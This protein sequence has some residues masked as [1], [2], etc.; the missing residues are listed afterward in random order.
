MV[1]F[2]SADGKSLLFSQ[3]SSA[4]GKVSGS[5]VVNYADTSIFATLVINGTSSS[6]IT[7]PILRDLGGDMRLVVNILGI[8][9]T[10]M[11]GSGYSSIVDSDGDGVPDSKDAFPKDSSKAFTIR[12]PSTGYNTLT[13]EDQYPSVGDKD[14]ND[15]VL[16]VVNEEDLNAKGEIVEIRT[17]YQHVARGAI[18]NTH[19][20]K[21][22]IPA[23]IGVS[24][25]TNTIYD[26]SGK[27]KKNIDTNNPGSKTFSLFDDLD[28]SETL[29][30]QWWGFIYRPV[31]NVY[32]CPL[33]INCFMSGYIAKTTIKFTTPVKR[34]VLGSS[35]Y[36]IYANV[37]TGKEIHL[38][39][40]YLVNGKDP[41]LDST[42]F[43]WAILVPG[44]FKWPKLE[45]F[46]AATIYNSYP[47]FG[48]WA[49]SKGTKNTDWYTKYD[50]SKV[51]TDAS[52]SS[53]I[54][55]K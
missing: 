10:N 26:G 17:R 18:S 33:G 40:K 42:G 11:G 12:I 14:L 6:Q 39:G 52:P 54:T 49:T 34:D 32:D 28:S 24:K 3:I 1:E 48:A 8:Q 50:G 7:I 19:S 21:L 27:Q 43:P 29:P 2:L 41:Y 9:I 4:D 51:Y 45:I 22:Q 46:P 35:P 37:S 25:F 5:F 36:D 55:A 31:Y 13:F 53:I 38:P 44:D 15:Y 30:W 23:S 20:L 16:Y 47:N